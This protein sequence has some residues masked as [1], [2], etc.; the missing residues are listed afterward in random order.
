MNVTKLLVACL[1]VGTPALALAQPDPNDG[2]EAA[3][4]DGSAAPGGGEGGGEA[5]GA[6]DASG[7]PTTVTV[8]ATT[9][10]PWTMEQIDRP[11]TLPKGLIRVQGD[12]AIAKTTTVTV[13]AMGNP[14]TSSGTVEALRLSGGY[15][16]SDV[17]EVG[18]SYSLALHP[19]EAK[20]NLGLNALYG[21]KEEQKLRIA[22][23]AALGLN[24]DGNK[25]GFGLGAAV[26]FHLNNKMMVFT[27]GNQLVFGFDPTKI[28][29]SLPVGFAYQATPNV[30][31]AAQTDLADFGLKPSGSQFIFADLTPLSVSGFYSPSNKMDFGVTISSIDVPHIGDFFAI[32]LTARIFTGPPVAGSAPVPAPA[33]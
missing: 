22:A 17:L 15:G 11:L 29:L 6:V 26:Q 33:M 5:G 28:I 24:L 21:I 12:L 20:G 8:G 27:P 32:L 9:A 19:F 23:T 14:T 16:V 4:D 31:V 3:P 18:A 13:D 30:F 10:L 7:V 2:S 25:F 1:V